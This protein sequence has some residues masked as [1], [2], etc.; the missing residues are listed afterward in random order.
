MT[1]LRTVSVALV[2]SLSLGCAFYAGQAGLS[3]TSGNARIEIPL[4]PETEDGQPCTECEIPLILV[5][6][7]ELGENVTQ[8]LNAIVQGLLSFFG[9]GEPIPVVVTL[10]AEMLDALRTDVDLEAGVSDE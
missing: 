8:V 7:G 10:D 6:G 1:I 2:L 5:R 3:I 9:A 4:V